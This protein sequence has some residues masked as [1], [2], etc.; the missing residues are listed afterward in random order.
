MLH[1]LSDEQINQYHEKGYVRGLQV[2]DHQGII[3]LNEG[4]AKLEQL[5]KPGETH[6]HIVNWH[7]TSHWLYN[8]CI[9]PQILSYV[10]GVLG[11]DFYLWGSHFFSKGPGAMD[12]VAWHQDA[13]YWPLKPHRSVTVWLAFVDA[14]EQNGAMKVI[15]GTHK[16][17]LLQHKESEESTNVLNL[18]LG[19]GSFSAEDAVSLSLKAGEISLH[20]DALVHG[21]PANPS[22]RWRIGLTM[23]FSATEV[24]CDLNEW[25]DF[26]VHLVHGQDKF[27]YNP[28]CEVPK[29]QFARPNKRDI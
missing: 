1:T 7:R 9:H 25:D 21:S 2:F 23:R 16:A 27:K 11:Q 19:E 24:K 26:A 8:V 5:L 18:Q 28:Y 10:A 13:P 3:E 6:F 12:T 22:E 29:E 20:D 14:D 4:M 15:P 17:G